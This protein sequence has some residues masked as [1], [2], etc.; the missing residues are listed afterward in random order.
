M[1]GSWKGDVIGVGLA[2]VCI[3]AL[4]GCVGNASPTAPS[5]ARTSDVSASGTSVRSAVGIGQ[6]AADGPSLAG[7][8]GRE[9]RYVVCYPGNGGYSQLSVHS[10][11]MS[12]A[13]QYCLK[14]LHGRVGGVVRAPSPQP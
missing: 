3:V 1:T 8:S 7:G 12:G 11:G 14:V 9:D 10:M 13:V 2:W 5:A 6:A 4:A